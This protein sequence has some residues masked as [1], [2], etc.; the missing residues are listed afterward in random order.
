MARYGNGANDLWSWLK[1]LAGG[2]ECARGPD[3]L[4]LPR[5]RSVPALRFF[6]AQFPA[7]VLSARSGHVIVYCLDLET[8]SCIAEAASRFGRDVYICDDLEEIFELITAAAASFY[9]FL[10]A[11]TFPGGDQDFEQLLSQTHQIEIPPWAFIDTSAY[12]STRTADKTCRDVSIIEFERS[13][14]ECCRSFDTVL[15]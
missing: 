13:F 5:A 8:G 6:P 1:G 7:P 3:E 10:I 14:V 4:Q 2:H 12:R 15:C 9:C 11:E